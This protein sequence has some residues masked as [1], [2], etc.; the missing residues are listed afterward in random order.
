MSTKAPAATYLG[1]RYI[2][3]GKVFGLVK[4]TTL[5][6]ICIFDRTTKKQHKIPVRNVRRMTRTEIEN[7]NALPSY[8]DPAPDQ[9]A[10]RA[11]EIR[12]SWDESTRKQRSQERKLPI[13]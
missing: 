2:T 7:Y 6:E 8:C 1:T 5:N 10:K 9:V 4:L 12:G 11:A 3:D 13:Q